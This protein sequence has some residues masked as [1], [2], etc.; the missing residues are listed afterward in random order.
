[1]YGT[2]GKRG[3]KSSKRVIGYENPVVCVEL[4]EGFGEQILG[5]WRSSSAQTKCHGDQLVLVGTISAL[6][7]SALN[8]LVYEHG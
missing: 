8:Q 1:M 2:V 6:G 7:K 5:N 4:G 3:E